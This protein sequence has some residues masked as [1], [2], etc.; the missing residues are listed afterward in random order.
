MLPDPDRQ[1]LA[2]DWLRFA[3]SDL[4]LAS[5]EPQDDILPETL[6][7]HAQQ[8]VEKGFKAVLTAR[9]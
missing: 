8:A 5:L 4:Q 7:F 9:R 3:R 1:K 6:A 2:L